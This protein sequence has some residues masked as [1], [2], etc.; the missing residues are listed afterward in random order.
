MTKLLNGRQLVSIIQGEIQQCD[1]EALS[2]ALQ[3]GAIV[4][5][6]REEAEVNLGMIPGA[7]HIPR[8]VLEMELTSLDAI[9]HEQD[10]LSALATRPVYLYCRSGARSALAAKSLESMGLTKVWSVAG[11]FNRWLALEKPI[12]SSK[13]AKVWEVDGLFAWEQGG[14]I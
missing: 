6:I 8:G 14:G 7:V 12:I 3:Q 9:S 2:E 10:P 5:D 1:C 4:I 13:E 11:G